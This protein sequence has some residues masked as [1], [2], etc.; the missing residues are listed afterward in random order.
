MEIILEKSIKEFISISLTQIESLYTNDV[1]SI[2]FSTTEWENY[3]NRKQFVEKIVHELKY[4]LE[5]NKFSNRNWTILFIFDEKQLDMYDLF[6]Q[7]ILS[8]QNQTNDYKQF[9]Y[10]ISSMYSVCKHLSEKCLCFF[11]SFSDYNI[12]E[13]ITKL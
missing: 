6:S 8:I 2:A 11:F 12:F 5:M 1:K 3:S 9:Y 7:A 10:P 13:N 4:Q